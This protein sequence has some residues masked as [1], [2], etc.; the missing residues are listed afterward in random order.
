MVPRTIDEMELRRYLLGTLSEEEEARQEELLLTEESYFE[1]LVLA[2]DE[3]IDDYVRGQLTAQEKERMEQRFLVPAGRRERLE[4]VRDLH[5]STTERAETARR[6]RDSSKHND[7]HT[8]IPLIAGSRRRTAITL[9]AGAAFLVIAVGAGLLVEIARLGNRIESLNQEQAKAQQ[10]ET[11]LH[12]EL[13]GLLDRQDQLSRE[14]EKEQSQRIQLQQDVINQMRPQPASRRLPDGDLL[15]IALAPGRIRDRGPATII[16]IQPSIKWVRL[17]LSLERAGHTSYRATLHTVEGKPVW[18]GYDLKPLR[19]DSDERVE[20][21]LPA[22]LL[23]PG[24]Y[25]VLLS[26]AVGRERIGTYYFTIVRK[27]Q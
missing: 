6:E 24:D 2:E 9:V 25:T 15:A 14:I 17:R 13:A 18:T 23:M 10:R 12:K 11:E 16:E 8:A 19:T 3:L 22:K 1:Q 26:P 27:S 5:R 20:I 7:G 4:L 21:L